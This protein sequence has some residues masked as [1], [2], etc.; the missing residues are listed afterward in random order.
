MITWDPIQF[1]DNRHLQ[2]YE[3]PDGS[4]TYLET[5]T[6]KQLIGLRNYMI[7]LISQNRPADQKYNAFCFIFSEQWFNL[8]AHDMRTALVNAVLENHRSQATPG[9]PMS[10]VISPSS[11]AS[12]RS[13]IHL[14][15]ASFKK[16]I[17][18]EASAYSILKDEHY[19]DKFQR[20]F[21]ITAKFHDVSEILDPTFTPGPSQEEKE[22]FEAKQ[23]FMYKVFN[24]T[25][26]TDIGRTKV[27]KNL[28]TID[29]QAVSK[30]Y[31]EYMTTASKGASEKRKLTHYVTNTVLDS[32]F[33]GTSQQFV[34]HF[35]EQFRRLDELTDLTERMP[36]STK[37]ALLQN[38][39]KD[40]P[41][42]SIVE[43]LDEYTSTTSGTGHVPS[44]THPT[45][46]FSSM[47]VLDMMLPILPLPLRERMYMQLM[48]PYITMVLLNPWGT[49][50]S[51]HRYTL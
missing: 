30:K 39:V 19:F 38:A 27:R 50:L 7:L 24:E 6:V 43:T 4:I 2:K 25:L 31:S 29:A 12:I 10:H 18:R 22:L 21:F 17:K 49:V 41:Q 11:S 36:E 8:T 26:L 14:E 5:N 34:L 23:V 33:R 32:Q 40:I 16:G 48:V 51:R 37:M 42:L 44:P 35:N 15:L 13:P 28:K 9:T 47:L 1:E 3:E 20:D 45:T 46:I